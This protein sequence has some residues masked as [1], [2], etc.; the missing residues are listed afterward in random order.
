[1]NSVSKCYNFETILS[2]I[3]KGRK[4]SLENRSCSE[5]SLLS[6]LL[7]ANVEHQLSCFCCSFDILGMRGVGGHNVKLVFLFVFVINK[8]WSFSGISQAQ[9]LRCQPMKGEKGGHC[10]HVSIEDVSKLEMFC[11]RLDVLPQFVITEASV[12]HGE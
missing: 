6:L 9:M 10:C 8:S 3:Q 1:M 7:I 12:E 5:T 11:K 2:A 4:K